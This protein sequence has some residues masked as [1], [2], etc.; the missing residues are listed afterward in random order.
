[1]FCRY[2]QFSKGRNTYFSVKGFTV[3]SNA[4]PIEKNK[5]NFFV[6][7]CFIKALSLPKNPVPHGSPVIVLYRKSGKKSDFRC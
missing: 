5:K 7:I 3:I 6:M 2:Q 4:V 1:M